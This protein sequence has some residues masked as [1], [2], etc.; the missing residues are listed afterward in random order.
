[1]VIVLLIVVVSGQQLETPLIT[2]HALF[3]GRSLFQ[4]SLVVFITS[5]GCPK[6]H[7]FYHVGLVSFCKKEIGTKADPAT[8]ADPGCHDLLVVDSKLGSVVINVFDS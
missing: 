4:W 7:G 5:H 2:G 8:T 1:M 6:E 3:D